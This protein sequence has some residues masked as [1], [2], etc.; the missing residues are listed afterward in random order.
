MKKNAP[1]LESIQ[2]EEPEGEDDVSIDSDI[3]PEDKIPPPR[4]KQVIA[5]YDP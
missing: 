5:V 4:E 3:I 1:P 2:S